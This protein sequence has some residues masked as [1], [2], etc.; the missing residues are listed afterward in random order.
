M[1]L[2]IDGKPG[3]NPTQ[4]SKDLAVKRAN[5][6]VLVRELEEKGLV[7]RRP[8]EHDKRS[9]GLEITAVGKRKLTSWIKLADLHEQ[10]LAAIIG[11]AQRDTFLRS[12]LRI[13]DQLNDAED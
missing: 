12:L 5:I 1:L 2:L 6:A 13:V 11:A 9:S 7:R 8:A 4:M 10:R 3:V